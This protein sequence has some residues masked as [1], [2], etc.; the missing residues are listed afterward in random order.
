MPP[1]D[2][3]EVSGH[4]IARNSNWDTTSSRFV[5]VFFVSLWFIE[6]THFNER[7]EGLL[8]G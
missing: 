8:T 5:F 3:A 7:V 4:H 1:P 2:Q 6:E